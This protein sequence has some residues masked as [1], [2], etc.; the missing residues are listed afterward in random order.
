MSFSG[1]YCTM[2][3]LFRRQSQLDKLTKTCRNAYIQSCIQSI[4]YGSFLTILIQ[5]WQTG[6][7][8][9]LLES[10]S[11]E[12]T[13]FVRSWVTFGY[14][15]LMLHFFIRMEQI[16]K[17]LDIVKSENPKYDLKRHLDCVRWVGVVCGF[18]AGMLITYWSVQVFNVADS[19]LIWSVITLM[20]IAMIGTGKDFWRMSGL[21]PTIAKKIDILTD[22]YVVAQRYFMEILKDRPFVDV[23]FDIVSREIRR[24]AMA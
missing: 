6:D 11:E 8:F 12:T 14:I 2:K 18:T 15:L 5:A 17:I 4:V 19:R 16:P 20:F 13:T 21:S 10:Y 3:Q 24:Q 9:F 1:G 7:A 23:D 22:R